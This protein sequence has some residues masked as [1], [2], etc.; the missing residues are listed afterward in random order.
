MNIMPISLVRNNL[1][2]LVQDLSESG[3]E[4]VITVNGRSKAVL[5]DFE[6]WESI[7]ETAEILAIP[8]AREAIKVGEEQSMR[9]EGVKLKDL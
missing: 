3:D 7:K 2:N 4:C 5:V 6:E 9:G 1:P 8:G